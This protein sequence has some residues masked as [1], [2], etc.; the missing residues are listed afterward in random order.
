MMNDDDFRIYFNQ[1]DSEEKHQRGAMYIQKVYRPREDAIS[2]ELLLRRRILTVQKTK[3]K[4]VVWSTGRVNTLSYHL[5][6]FNKA[7]V[8]TPV[9]FLAIIIVVVIPPPLRSHFG[10][11]CSNIYVGITTFFSSH[12]PL[13]LLDSQIFLSW[14]IKG[15]C[16]GRIKIS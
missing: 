10:I 16:Y 2:L 11:F 1:E 3:G 6:L 5:L 15:L 12:Y 7:L 9:M 8:I 13:S 4:I 14:S